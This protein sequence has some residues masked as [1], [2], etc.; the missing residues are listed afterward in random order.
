MFVRTVF[1]PIICDSDVLKCITEAVILPK[2]SGGF[3]L[4]PSTHQGLRCTP[5]RPAPPTQAAAGSL[6][7]FQIETSLN[8]AHNLLNCVIL[9]APRKASTARPGLQL[10]NAI[11]PQTKFQD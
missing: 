8:W 7:I 6:V 10:H 4:C 3:A 2:F 1:T 11:I 9:W 5:P